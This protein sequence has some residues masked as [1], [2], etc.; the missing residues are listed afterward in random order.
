MNAERFA[1]WPDGSPAGPPAYAVVLNAED[2]NADTIRPRLE[3]V[4]T[5]LDRV[6]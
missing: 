1:D 4:G 5:D 6:P 3:G 2:D